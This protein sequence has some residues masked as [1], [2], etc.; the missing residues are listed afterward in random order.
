MAA[1]AC[2]ALGLL[3]CLSFFVEADLKKSLFAV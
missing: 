3:C 2:G 1:I